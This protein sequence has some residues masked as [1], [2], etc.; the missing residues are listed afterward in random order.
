MRKLKVARAPV[1]APRTAGD[2]NVSWEIVQACCELISC[3]RRLY[4]Y[5]LVF[6]YYIVA[7]RKKREYIR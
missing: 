4:V 2:A 6:F 1:H 3:S 7:K 5:K